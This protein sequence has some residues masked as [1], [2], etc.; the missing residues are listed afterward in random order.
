[1][2][3]AQ[4][5]GSTSG[6]ASA[7]SAS[8]SSASRP[9]D[10]LARRGPPPNAGGRSEIQLLLSKFDVMINQMQDYPAKDTINSLTMLAESVQFAPDIVSFLE[11]KIHRVRTRCYLFCIRPVSDRC[12]VPLDSTPRRSARV[13]C[14]CEFMLCE[15]MWMWLALPP[16]LV[17]VHL[18]L[19]VY[20]CA[21]DAFGWLGRSPFP[22]R[23]IWLEAMVVEVCDY[24]Q[25]ATWD[26]SH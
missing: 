5:A 10:V 19:S 13:V 3:M 20:I 25:A 2:A 18:S 22:L 4:F 16:T 15:R 1:M 12:S 14:M 26:S 9:A 24:V 8:S 21:F 11:T 7:P 23:R 6:S 17:V